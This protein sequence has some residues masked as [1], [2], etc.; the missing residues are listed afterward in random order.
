MRFLCILVILAG[1]LGTANATDKPKETVPSTQLQTQS[2]GQQNSQSQQQSA[3]SGANSYSERNTAIGLA[4]TSPVPLFDPARCYLP[5]KGI[6][7]TRQV[8][9][10]LWTGDPRLVRDPQCMADLEAARAHE[11]KMAELELER[12]R[13]VNGACEERADRAE[14]ACKVGK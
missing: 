13:L 7:R 1:A 11:V 14:D 12:L 3:V 9:F 10:G 8:F 6:R 2:Q 4:S 5:P